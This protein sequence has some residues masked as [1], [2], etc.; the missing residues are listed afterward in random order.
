MGGEEEME[1]L[2]DGSRTRNTLDVDQQI[3]KCELFGIPTT[4]IYILKVKDSRAR[5]LSGLL[6]IKWM[7]WKQLVAGVPTDA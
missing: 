4:L 1:E 6:S 2:T 3:L 7:L 5:S